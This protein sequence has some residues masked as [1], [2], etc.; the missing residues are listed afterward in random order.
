MYLCTCGPCGDKVSW[1][2]L[3]D[4]LFIDG[5]GKMDDYFSGCT[6]WED[7]A[8]LVRSVTIS[9]GVTS[10]GCRAFR[11]LTALTQVTIPASV[12]RIGMDAFSGCD[13]LT[14]ITV[15]RGN[16]RYF[17]KNGMLYDRH[18]CHPLWIPK[19][20]PGPVSR[21][22]VDED[23]CVFRIDT[24]FMGVGT[25][26]G[27]GSYG[28]SDTLIEIREAGGIVID[29]ECIYLGKV[30]QEPNLFLTDIRTDPDL[31]QR[32]LPFRSDYS[33]AERHPGLVN[34]ADRELTVIVSQNLE[35]VC[36]CFI[37][38][39]VE[40]YYDDEELLVYFKVTDLTEE[41]AAFLIR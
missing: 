33:Y 26:S 21:F 39:R 8:W 24:G 27:I 5:E 4:G 25:D 6:P 20:S 41:E 15:A 9:P 2:L 17:M 16:P 32:D 23:Y 35:K 31:E 3:G 11:G 14:E 29:I 28:S 34:V 7:I 37:S 40:Y 30:M 38:G 18:G 22:A 19:G 36:S 13:A 10:I 12:A 1:E